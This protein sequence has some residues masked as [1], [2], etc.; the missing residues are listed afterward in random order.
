MRKGRLK[1]RKKWLRGEKM[2]IDRWIKMLQREGE[3]KEKNE[4]ERK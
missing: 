3:E 4:E 2:Y 1:E